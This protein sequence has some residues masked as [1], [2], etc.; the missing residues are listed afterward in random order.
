MKV[1]V[2]DVLL[3]AD[4]ETAKEFKEASGDYF[5]WFKSND[6]LIIYNED[7]ELYSIKEVELTEVDLKEI[8]EEE[9]EENDDEIKEN[10][11]RKQ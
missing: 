2:V 7:S 3:N 10:N 9:E 1:E 11:L 6:F 8:E 5:Y 4:E